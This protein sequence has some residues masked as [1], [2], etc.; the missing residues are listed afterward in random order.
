MKLKKGTRL[1][2]YEIEGSIGAGGMGEVFRARDTRL[3]RVVAIKVISPHLSA[4]DQLLARFEREARVVSSLS[5]PNICTLYDV[6]E[7]E[8]EGA[9]EVSLHY[10]VM[11]L[12]EGE[13]LDERIRRGPLSVSEV[14]ALGVQISRA[15]EHAHA[16]GVIHRDLKPANIMLTIAGVKLLDFGL[17][18]TLRESEDE[19]AAD[20]S[21]TVQRGLT[22][23][24]VVLGTFQYMAPEQ[25]EGKEADA[26]TDIFAFGAVLYEMATGR[27]AFEGSSRASLIAAIMAID[28][29]EI[30]EVRPDVAPAL[31]R[32]I[33]S[34]LAKNA[35]DRWQSA[36]DVR[37]ALELSGYRSQ[38]ETSAAPRRG[39]VVVPWLIAGLATVAALGLWWGLGS[40]DATPR[41]AVFEIE[42]GKMRYHWEEAPVRLSPDA[43]R[44]AFGLRGENGAAAGVFI[45]D[46][47]RLEPSRIIEAWVYDLS[48]S[49]DGQ[50]ILFFSDSAMRKI[51]ATGGPVTVLSTARDS[52]GASW[53]PDGTILF[54]PDVA[55]G[56]QRIEAAGGEVRNVTVVDEAA[57]DIGH[58]RPEFLPDGRHFLFLLHSRNASRRG[59]WL[60]SLDGSMRPLIGTN[61]APV[62]AAPDRVLYFHDGSLYAQRLDMDR[63]E[64]VGSP[65]RVAEEVA[66]S[67]RWSN[68]GFTASR[69]GAMAWHRSDGVKESPIV[70]YDLSGER[71]ADP[72]I[73]G[74]NLDLSPDGGRLAVQSG[75]EFP[76]IWVID[77][78]RKARSRTT[79]DEL[80]EIGPVWSP[81][82]KWIAYV[83][84]DNPWRLMRVSSNGMSLP[85]ELLSFK[86]I[87]GEVIDW[88]SDG[89]WL[90]VEIFSDQNQLDLKLVDLEDSER[91][92]IPL[93]TTR[94]EESSARFS[95][96]AKWFAYQ[97][98]DTGRE[99]I[100]VQPFPP[101]GRRW[102]ISTEG[103]Q[104]PRWSGDGRALYWIGGGNLMVADIEPGDGFEVRNTR[105][106][107]EGTWIDWVIDSSGERVYVS[108]SSGAGTS[109]IVLRLP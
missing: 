87:G 12:V 105:P 74:G 24:G 64:I 70:A 44:L 28:P 75:E 32:V 50:E 91:K 3:D 40:S 19:L 20:A 52:R 49:W 82:G 48:W 2:P 61:S 108:E 96:D 58:W 92:L 59:I 1:G 41:S 67:R 65:E 109:P 29:P 62:F 102:Q 51:A 31:A 35:A 85:E 101:D 45:R 11:E 88:S 23:E 68:P 55:G 83:I 7:L 69:T 106:L 93:L 36:H 78:E 79:N 14:V 98:N 9:T 104:A 90:L 77:L 15:L 53:G 73:S 17:S 47:D 72:G 95:P 13:T 18:K 107:F 43:R 99:E 37:I 60:G 81:D 84:S 66:Y 103:G 97:S 6:G 63:L 86:E 57:G 46:L 21:H 39:R 94:F 8:G 100:L 71:L 4:N 33:A 25:A 89:R 26:R 80:A 34:C 54:S 56:I 76:D 38:E 10:F 22:E 30:S 27:R 5:H 16:R 42:S